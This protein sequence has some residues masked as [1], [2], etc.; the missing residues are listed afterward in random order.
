M[1][2]E[3][4]GTTY[5]LVHEAAWWLPAQDTRLPAQRNP[6]QPEFIVYEGAFSH[7]YRLRSEDAEIE[8]GRGDAL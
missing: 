1:L 2:P 6:E 3:L 8:F 5:L 4:I 7:R